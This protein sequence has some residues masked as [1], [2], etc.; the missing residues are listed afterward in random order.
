MRHQKIPATLWA[1]PSTSDG[2]AS[3]LVMLMPGEKLHFN[4][5]IEFTPE[6]AATEN[7]PQQPSEIGTLR[8]ANEA[9]TGEMCILFGSTA[10]VEMPAPAADLGPLPDFATVD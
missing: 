7:A 6:R 10:E 2:A 9:Y 1:S 4:C 8:F 3:G 5:H